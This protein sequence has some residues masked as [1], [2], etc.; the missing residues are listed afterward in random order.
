MTLAEFI[1]TDFSLLAY[2]NNKLIFR[3]KKCGIEPL[4]DYL[5]E[6]SSLK[7]GVV[8]FDKIVGRC[9]AL[10]L[11]KANAGMVYTP[12]ISKAGLSVLRKYQIPCFYLKKIP[13]VLNRSKTGTCPM[14]LFSYKKSPD[15]LYHLLLKGTPPHQAK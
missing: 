2:L 6:H 1:R 13:H 10:L 7:S 12:E 15:Q 9:A 14:E 3:S 11:I 5:Q 4:L 8:F